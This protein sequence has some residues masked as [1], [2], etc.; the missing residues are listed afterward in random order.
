MLRQ[1]GLVAI[2]SVVFAVGC[3]PSTA[4]PDAL[5]TGRSVYA[6]NCSTCHGK[7]GQ[8]GVGP[9]LSKV[10]EVWPSC[11]DHQTWI[12][13]GSDRWQLEHGSTYGAFDAPITN[14]MPAHDERLT[15]DEIAA[16]AAFE[17]VEYGGGD[18]AAELRSCG[19]PDD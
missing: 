13:L 9:N 16:V 11:T 14:V 6:D 8:G 10:L 19:L 3:A 7:R 18:A 15:D 12:A 2:A 5:R 17:R 4:T 1:L